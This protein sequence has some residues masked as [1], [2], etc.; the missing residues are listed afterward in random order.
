MKRGP[1]VSVDVLSE[2]GELLVKQLAIRDA[3]S[4]ASLSFHHKGKEFDLTFNG[5]L[6]AATIDELLEKNAFLTGWIKGNLST[7]IVLD[8]PFNSVAHG[9]LQGAGL[10]YPWSGE[11]PMQI[12]TFSLN[13]QR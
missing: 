5:T 12:A 2:R 6:S 10:N 7:R 8:Q 11:G 1:E 13:A 9:T 3:R 4:D